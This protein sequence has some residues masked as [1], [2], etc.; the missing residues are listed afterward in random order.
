MA[1]L[2]EDERKSV[3]CVSYTG[4]YGSQKNIEE[5]EHLIFPNLGKSIAV[6]T[7]DFNLSQI[8]YCL[9]GVRKFRFQRELLDSSL[10]QGARKFNIPFYFVY[11]K[12]SETEVL[13]EEEMRSIMK[14]LEKKKCYGIVIN[15]EK[16]PES[17]WVI[18]L[19]TSFTESIEILKQAKL[20]YIGMVSDMAVLAS[21]KFDAKSLYIKAPQL[22]EGPW[23]KFFFAPHIAITFVYLD[24]NDL[25]L[26]A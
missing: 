22:L 8:N 13:S 15:C 2:S 20:G 16:F 12:V 7:M 11:P 4:A 6:N 1:F 10:C 24:L 23:S 17:E 26:T 21:K 9:S 5:I 25:H 18:K 3:T 19:T 14:F